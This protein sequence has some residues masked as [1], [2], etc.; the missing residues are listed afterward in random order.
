MVVR[1]CQAILRNEDEAL[2][3]AQDV[4][5]SLL[6]HGANLSGTYPSSLLYT[7]ATNT[8]LNRLRARKRDA[9]EPP[10]TSDGEPGYEEAEARMLV[11]AILEDES[12]QD[13]AIVYMNVIDGMSLEETGKAAGLSISGVRKRVLAFKK[14]ARLKLEE[15]E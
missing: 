13:K 11:S 15:G 14:R 2:D 4:F 8:S 7:I 6:L 12:P 1:R 9:G 3:A 10:E 5:A